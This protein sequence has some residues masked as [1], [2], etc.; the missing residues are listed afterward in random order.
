MSSFGKGARVFGIMARMGAATALSA[1]APVGIKAG[2]ERNKERRCGPRPMS[3]PEMAVCAAGRRH[4]MPARLLCARGGKPSRE[5]YEIC[6]ISA[7]ICRKC[8]FFN[9]GVAA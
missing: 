7:S 8:L 5:A 6:G 3:V 2:L 1:G 4:L 9:N